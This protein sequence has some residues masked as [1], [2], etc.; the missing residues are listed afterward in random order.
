MHM[1]WI[2][3][4]TVT[5]AKSSL[6]SLKLICIKPLI[7]LTGGA[8]SKSFSTGASLVVGATRCR[9]VLP[10][11]FFSTWNAHLFF[12]EHMWEPSPAY[13]LLPMTLPWQPGSLSTTIKLPY[14]AGIFEP[15]SRPS[16]SLT[17]AFLSL[18]RG[19]LRLTNPP[20]LPLV[21]EIYQI[22]NISFLRSCSVIP[23][24]CVLEGIKKMMKKF[25]LFGI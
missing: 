4:V 16:P 17:L 25:D 20:L 15:W 19:P 21:I 9:M 23:I 8:L 10:V 11:P 5:V 3:Y 18:P 2:F 24:T 12:I 7:R 14:L 13:R 1:P 22:R 6:S